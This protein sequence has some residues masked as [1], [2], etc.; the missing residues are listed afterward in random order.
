MSRSG[1]KQQRLKQEH[2]GLMEKFASYGL[3]PEEFCRLAIL[4]NEIMHS[5]GELRRGLLQLL[6]N[7]RSDTLHCLAEIYSRPGTLDVDRLSLAKGL[8]SESQ[9]LLDRPWLK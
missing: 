6:L 4:E 8:L 2:A 7:L 1:N 9:R 3:S 5:G